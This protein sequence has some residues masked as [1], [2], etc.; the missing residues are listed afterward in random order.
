MPDSLPRWDL[1]NLYSGLD[2]PEFKA[3]FHRLGTLLDELQTLFDQRGIRRAGPTATTSAG[4]L[5]PLLQDILQCANAIALL[6]DLLGAFA[7]ALLTTNSY[8]AAAARETSKLELLSTR[9]QQ[10]DVRF[11]GWVGSLQPAALDAACRDPKLADYRFYLTDAA[12]QSQYLM[13]EDLE[14]LAAELCLDA[15]VAFGKLQGNVTSQLKVPF[16][17]DGAPTELP[18]TVIRNFLLRYRSR[19]CASG[20]I[21]PR[22]Q[23]WDS[24][25]TTVAACLNGVKG[26]ALTLARR[27]GRDSVLEVALDDNRIDRPTLDAMLGAIREALPMFRR[28]LRSQSPQ[29]GTCQRQVAV[30]GFVRPAGSAD[31]HFT[32]PEAR[33][34]IVEKFGAFSAELGDY[35]ARAFD[36]RWID[37]EPRDG[38]RGGAFCMDVMGVEESRILANFDG[39]F[40]QVSTLAHELGHGYHNHCQ[41]G[42]DA[43]AARLPFDAGR[44]RQHLLRNADRRGGL[45]RGLA[46]RAADDSRNAACGA[47]QV[48]LDISSRF[49]SS[50]PCSSAAPAA[51]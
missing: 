6:E 42:L 11:K 36:E 18:I 43:A 2:S 40:E 24:I 33:E 12:R 28:Y 46:G 23:G 13:A 32:W 27:R 50:R 14:N 34:F 29:A 20:P 48:C 4:D 41:A 49:S 31:R 47:T 45:A 16:E 51:S 39:S 7:Y 17:R 26:T 1:S 22:S 25:R 5:S 38:K 21:T 30:V 44:N 10:L 35:A 8:D 37:A 9:R 19:T 3:D 15:G